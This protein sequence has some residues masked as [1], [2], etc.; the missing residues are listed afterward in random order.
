MSLLRL[1]K[2]S[3]IL[4]GL[5]KLNHGIKWFQKIFYSKYIFFV[6][7]LNLLLFFLKSIHKF[8]KKKKPTKDVFI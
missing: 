2:I 7:T 6:K 1:H 4:K 8:K 3:G 5:G